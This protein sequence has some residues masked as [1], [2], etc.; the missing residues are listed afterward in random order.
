M[1]T[2]LGRGGTGRVYPSFEGV[3]FI[4]KD[5]DELNP[6]QNIRLDSGR[7]HPPKTEWTEPLN[8]PT[9]TA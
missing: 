9:S 2:A 5:G 3:C 4:D 1:M 6:P 7:N 8:H